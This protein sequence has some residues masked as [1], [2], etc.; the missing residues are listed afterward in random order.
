MRVLDAGCGTGAI[1][2][3]IAASVGPDGIVFGVDR[4]EANLAIARQDYGRA[5]NLRFETADVLTLSDRFGRE[6]DIVTAARTIQWVSEPERALVQMK[7]ATKPGGRVIVLDY[8]LDETYW[9]P[10]PPVSF[11]RFYQAFLD[12]RTSNGWDNHM[13]SHLPGLFRA[14]G[15]A[16]VATYP[17]DELLTRNDPNFENPYASGIWLYVIQT[18]GPTLVEAGF[19]DDSVRVRAGQEYETYVQHTL[20]VQRHSMLTVDGSAT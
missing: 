14:A 18:L 1:T 15:L 17:S 6:F 5:E 2:A 16:D 19:L 13:A 4:D 8:N 20:Q 3:H 10:E 7:N 9:E 12:W 11:R